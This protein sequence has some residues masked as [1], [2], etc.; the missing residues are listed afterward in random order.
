MAPVPGMWLVLKHISKTTSR[1]R[2]SGTGGCRAMSSTWA[3]P[4]GLAPVSPVNSVY[5]A[6][7][8]RQSSEHTG[9]SQKLHE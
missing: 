4:C 8:G 2:L 3:S 1:T 6:E 9:K 7:I 5:K